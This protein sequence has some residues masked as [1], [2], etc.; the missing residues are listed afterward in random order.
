M[1]SL[2]ASAAR[3]AACT[4]ASLFLF[5]VSTSASAQPDL[6]SSDANGQLLVE[7]GTLSSLY[8]LED[9]TPDGRYALFS[10][11]ETC[12]LYRKNRRTGEVLTVL[13]NTRAD[14][15][16][17]S[18]YSW[19]NGAG[20]SAD[21]NLI[22]ASP[23]QN[24]GEPEL[25]STDPFGGELYSFGNVV[26]VARKNITTGE[27]AEVTREYTG[28]ANDITRIQLGNGCC[29]ASQFRELSADGDTALVADNITAI[30]FG[31]PL[32]SPTGYSIVKIAAQTVTAVRLPL[33]ANLDVQPVISK[34]TMSSDG[35]RL[36]LHVATVIPNQ[37][38]D[39]R[40]QQDGP[41][42]PDAVI[43]CG[44]L[45]RCDVIGTLPEDGGP[46]GGSWWCYGYEPIKQLDQFLLYNPAPRATRIVYTR[47]IDSDFLMGAIA[48]SGDG[49][50]GFFVLT[51][52]QPV[53]FTGELGET[54]TACPDDDAAPTDETPGLKRLTLNDSAQNAN[55]ENV[56]S[57]CD[58]L[59]P[60][61]ATQ[62]MH[63]SA[64]DNGKRILIGL[65]QL[66]VRVPGPIIGPIPDPITGPTPGPLP[67]F[68][69]PIDSETS[70][71]CNYFEGPL[72]EEGSL[73]ERAYYLNLPGGNIF[74]PRFYSPL[75][76][77][78]L[79]NVA[80]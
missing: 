35:A 30:G 14:S 47:D 12:T 18:G 7:P 65:G 60:L 40:I 72:Y 63:L 73:C 45:G 74:F 54:P 37:L 80:T 24:L 77:W 58:N 41:T 33:D 26:V 59:A 36:L 3:L 50:Y 13:E 70:A 53:C 20:I 51:D 49:N 69:P 66:F 78:Y 48:L 8:H 56:P 31:Q 10:S 15:T 16:D 9:L 17:G 64:A 44:Q 23:T 27:V 42:G 67:G 32:T 75:Y 76:S 57:I 4:A 55:E 6:V 39:P 62:C 11:R 71:L 68:Y 79:T 43:I 22:A 52:M 1:G 2:K 5:T 29:Y 46:I 61:S 34:A 28:N 25:I 38:P 19:C 21:G